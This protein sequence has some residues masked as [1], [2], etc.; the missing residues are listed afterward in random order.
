M[1][2]D[3]F[4]YFLLLLVPLC[5]LPFAV[6]RLLATE[7]ARGRTVG[8]AYLTAEARHL[9]G[10]MA[11]AYRDWPR[12]ELAACPVLVEVVDEHGLTVRGH[13]PFPDDDR[14]FGEA[15]LGLL[16]PGSSVRVA[17]PG[18][19]GLGAVRRREMF[20]MELAAFGLC[21]F[22]ILLGSG[23]IIRAILRA[24]RDARRQLDFVADFTHR[25]KT[26][27]TSISLC[28]ELARAGRLTDARRQE[29]VETIIGEAA[30]LDALVDEVLAHVKTVRHG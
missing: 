13:R 10:D 8:R 21:G 11:M 14:C 16:R 17:W 20:L 25:L 22:F 18:A 9:V 4:I 2:K 15:P 19:R 5:V 1:N 29:S 24:R 3:L 27:L 6:H 23:L 26:P 28:A 7:L 30:K 12:A